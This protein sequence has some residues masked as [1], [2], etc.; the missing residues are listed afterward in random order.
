MPNMMSTPLERILTKFQPYCQH[1]NIVQMLL[2]SIEA[3]VADA[4]SPRENAMAAIKKLISQNN[5]FPSLFLPKPIVR[6]SLEVQRVSK[7]HRRIIEAGIMKTVLAWNGSIG[8]ELLKYCNPKPTRKR[9]M[10]NLAVLPPRTSLMFLTSREHESEE[11]VCPRTSFLLS[12]D[13]HGYERPPLE[14]RLALVDHDI[15]NFRFFTVPQR[16]SLRKLAL[17]DS[18][19][20]TNLP[21]VVWLRESRWHPR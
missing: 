14:E 1:S 16:G 17:S 15:A 12:K 6:F 9:D 7:F 13:G 21:A 5:K 2:P 18:K 3:L 20:I 10:N 11:V 19:H 8:R 4:L